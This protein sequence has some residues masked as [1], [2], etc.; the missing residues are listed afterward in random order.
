M[1]TFDHPPWLLGYGAAYQIVKQR[2]TLKTSLGDWLP[3]NLIGSISPLFFDIL[4][5][6]AQCAKKCNDFG[7][8]Q[9][10]KICAFLQLKTIIH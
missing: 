10:P 1:K 4:H 5:K 3:D 2:Y 9:R 6:F 8:S 7:F